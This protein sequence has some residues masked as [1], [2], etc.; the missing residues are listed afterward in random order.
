MTTIILNLKDFVNILCKNLSNIRGMPMGGVTLFTAGMQ[1]TIG[2]G[3]T[4]LT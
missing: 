4:A 3:T 2:N 1:T